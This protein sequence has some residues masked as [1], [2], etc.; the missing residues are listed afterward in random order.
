MM[1]TACEHLVVDQ[2]VSPK[3]PEGCEECIAMGDG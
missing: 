1:T 2:E 3:T